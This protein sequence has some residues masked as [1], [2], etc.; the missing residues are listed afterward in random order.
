[1]R[2]VL[3]N[4][5]TKCLTTWHHYTDNSFLSLRSNLRKNSNIKTSRA[6][7]RY[8]NVTGAL[9]PAQAQ[10]AITS[11]HPLHLPGG[12]GQAVWGDSVFILCVFSWKIFHWSTKIFKSLFCTADIQDSST[13]DVILVCGCVGFSGHKFLLSSGAAAQHNAAKYF[14]HPKLFLR[15]QFLPELLHFPA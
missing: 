4:F 5:C 7:Y 13:T 2:R 15:P 9:L 3:D 8:Q 12:P 1:M 14:F 10:H 6:C 11:R